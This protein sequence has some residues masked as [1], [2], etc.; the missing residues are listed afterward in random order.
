MQWL[1]LGKGLLP[2][3]YWEEWKVVRDLVDHEQAD[4]RDATKLLRE[5]H[6][7][8]EWL[9]LRAALAVCDRELTRKQDA[10]ATRSRRHAHQRSHATCK[11]YFSVAAHTHAATGGDDARRSATLCQ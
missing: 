9:A 7:P 3:E 5:H 10:I 8:C 6:D 1:R 2:D 4:S 11:R